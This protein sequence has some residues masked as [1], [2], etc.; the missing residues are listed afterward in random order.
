[1]LSDNAHMKS[2]M[3]PKAGR[4]GRSLLAGLLRCRRCGRM[5]HVAYSGTHGEVPR[6]HCRGAQIN[7]GTDWASNQP[8][9]PYTK[10][11]ESLVALNGAALEINPALLAEKER[12]LFAILASMKR[13]IVAYS[14]GAD[15]AYLAWAAN[16]ALGE[17][18]RGHHRRL[19]VAAR[20]AQARRRGVCPRVRLPSRIHRNARVR[21]SR[22]TSRTTRT[23]A[24]IA[25][26]SC[27]RASRKWAASAALTTSSTGST[28]TTWATTGPARRRQ[29]APRQSAAG[30]RR[31]EQGRNPRAFA[32]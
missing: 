20:I 29:A 6:Y 23:A 24:S 15:S 26:T 12:T 31:L 18:C 1:M 9:A 17:N 13:V 14:G 3:E 22:T 10:D 8:R 16:R 25:R 30:G 2:R 32:R 19:R 5:L 27:S 21:K 28:S 11:M 4:G 7:H